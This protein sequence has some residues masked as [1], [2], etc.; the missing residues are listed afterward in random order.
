MDVL[1]LVAGCLSMCTLSPSLVQVSS[2][3]PG[4]IFS[5]NFSLSNMH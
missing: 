4:H 1:S 2:C 3:D 5:P